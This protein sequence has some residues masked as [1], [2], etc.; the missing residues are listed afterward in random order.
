MGSSSRTRRQQEAQARNVGLKY[1]DNRA[2]GNP[3]VFPM[4]HV[5]TWVDVGD[6]SSSQ[7]YIVDPKSKNRDNENEEY[8]MDGKNRGINKTVEFEF[9]TS[10]SPV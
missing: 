2:S 5:E 10:Q 8:V 7:E 1:G 6:R 3:G 4:T 9:H